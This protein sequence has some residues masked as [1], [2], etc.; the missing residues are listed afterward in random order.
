MLTLPFSDIVEE[1]VKNMTSAVDNKDGTYTIYH[2]DE[3]VAVLSVSASEVAQQQETVQEPQ[4]QTPEP[5]EVAIAPNVPVP[6][7]KRMWHWFQRA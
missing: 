3:P 1:H 4:V 7:Y 2:G 5:E 6:W